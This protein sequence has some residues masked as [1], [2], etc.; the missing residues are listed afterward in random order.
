MAESVEKGGTRQAPELVASAFAAASVPLAGDP[1]RCRR[2][3]NPA[4]HGAVPKAGGLVS[5]LKVQEYTWCM[6]GGLRG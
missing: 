5:F 2:I 4:D 3:S 6:K 1:S